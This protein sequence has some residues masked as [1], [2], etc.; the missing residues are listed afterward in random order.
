MTDNPIDP[1]E[2]YPDGLAGDVFALPSGLPAVLLLGTAFALLGSYTGEAEILHGHEGGPDVVKLGFMV[3]A[4]S[5]TDPDNDVDPGCKR[6]YP[7]PPAEL[8][9]L[10]ARAVAESRN[11]E[12]RAGRGP[13]IEGCTDLD[14]NAAEAVL[15]VLLQPGRNGVIR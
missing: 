15:A 2:T 4:C 12:Y 7:D 6:H 10:V 1:T 9:A 11:W 5:C 13:H 3:P 8:V 14:I